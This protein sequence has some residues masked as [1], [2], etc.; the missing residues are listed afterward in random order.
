MC[1]F[2]G[3]TYLSGPFPADNHIISKGYGCGAKA[4]ITVR[5]YNITPILDERV[6]CDQHTVRPIM[7][8]QLIPIRHLTPAISDVD[9]HTAILEII[10]VNDMIIAEDPEARRVDK[11]ISIDCTTVAMAQR[12][13]RRAVADSIIS[14]CN[15]RRL[16]GDQLVLAMTVLEQVVLYDAV[17]GRKAK[18]TKAELQGFGAVGT[19]LVLEYVKI[20]MVDPQSLGDLASFATYGDKFSK[21]VLVL[22][23][24]GIDL[25]VRPANRKIVALSRCL[26]YILRPP[27]E[28]CAVIGAGM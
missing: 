27:A 23:N 19:A 9:R 28:S 24:V 21:R 13:L 15:L 4:V 25:M 2:D 16:D 11:I 10:A 18:S 8:G 5:L 20:I 12:E 14:K 26:E 22:K 3:P 6:K 7:R 17:A 1:V